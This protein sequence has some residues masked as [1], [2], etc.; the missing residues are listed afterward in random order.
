MDALAMRPVIAVVRMLWRIPFG[1]TLAGLRGVALVLALVTL[2]APGHASA[3]SCWISNAGGFD[4]GT[5]NPDK[6]TDT[7]NNVAYTC[8]SNA[9]PTYFRVCMFLAEGDEIPGV[10]PRHMT[11][12][13]GAQLAYDLY[14]D[15]ARTQTVGPP[16]Q[17]GGYPVISVPI[18]VPASYGIADL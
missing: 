11:N 2:W 6:P 13:N 16:P 8:Q 14:S 9:S 5:V 12:Y 7:Q 15:P 10:N 18:L 1:P 4:F 3:Q 17:G